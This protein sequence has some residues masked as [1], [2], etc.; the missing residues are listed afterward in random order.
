MRLH[1][2]FKRFA[3]YSAALCVVMGNAFIFISE[4]SLSEVVLQT[5]CWQPF[6][7][8]LN[9]RSYIHRLAR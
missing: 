2:P 4:I 3:Q 7:N 5:G 9:R 6:S 8:D 1:I